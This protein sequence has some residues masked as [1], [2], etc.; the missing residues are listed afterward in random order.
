MVARCL[1][2]MISIC[3][4]CFSQWYASLPDSRINYSSVLTVP[5]LF[6]MPIYFYAMSRS[7]HVH[8][9]FCVTYIC[10]AR[11]ILPRLWF[12]C[13]G[14][15]DL[16]LLC[17][18]CPDV[19]L[20][21]LCAFCTWFISLIYSCKLY[22]L[23]A[24]F[25]CTVYFPCSDSRSQSQPHHHSEP[26]A[27]YHFH[28]HS[29]SRY[30]SWSHLGSYS[31]GSLFVLLCS[32]LAESFLGWTDELS[33]F[34]WI[35]LIYMNW[36]ALI[37]LWTEMIDSIWFW[38]DLIWFDW[39]SRLSILCAVSVFFRSVPSARSFLPARPFL[40]ALFFLPPVFIF[41]PNF[42]TVF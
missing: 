25:I 39:L 6:S 17:A 24:V 28:D 18:T 32:I 36:V 29:N 42:L 2:C 4:L 20:I 23:C 14:S 22:V 15:R 21:V 33:W 40:E 8:C 7:M 10:S 30:C 12:L 27:Q 37:S 38:L 35:V 16:S 19:P 11:C 41:N 31:V 3:A 5:F 1:F 13:S 26:Y 34:T 9:L